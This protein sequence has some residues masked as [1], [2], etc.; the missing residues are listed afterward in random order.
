MH[1]WHIVHKQML[2]W[3]EAY[4]VV[5]A[6]NCGSVSDRVSSG[7]LAERSLLIYCVATDN[8]LISFCLLYSLC[9][10]V[11][12]GIIAPHNPFC[13]SLIKKALL[14]QVRGLEGVSMT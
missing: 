2:F 9:Y 12:V 10:Y 4:L 13:L 11:C 3:V 5:E 8:Q 1:F 7:F 14:D 6:M